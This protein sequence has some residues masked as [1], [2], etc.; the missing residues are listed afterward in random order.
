M[1]VFSS[2]IALEDK[3]SPVAAKAEHEL[4]ILNKTLVQTQNALIKAQATGDIKSFK[5]LTQKSA[6]LEAA[7]SI[8]PKPLEQVAKGTEDVASGSMAAEGEMAAMTGGLSVAIGVIIAVGAALGACVL[9]LAEFT[10][11]CVESKNAA[12]STWNA[13]GQGEIAGEDV[14]NMLDDLKLKLGVTKDQ[15]GQFA[16]GFL[17][18]GITG[19]EALES[20]TTAAASAEAI[21]KGAG[22]GFTTLFQ[23]VDAA[24]ASSTKN[25]ILPAK[26]LQKALVAA[27]LN[28]KDMAKEMGMSEEAFSSQMSKGGIDAKK[29]GDAMQ[30]AVTKKG[31][32]ALENL[33]NSSANLKAILQENIGDMFEDLGEIV[34]PFMA[35]VKSLFNIFQKDAP[36]AK[37]MTAGIK[38][39]MTQIF[40][41]ATK[42]VPI[43]KHFLLDLIIYGLKAYIGVKPLIKAIKEFAN[44][45][46]GSEKINWVLDQLATVAKVIGVALL[47]VVAVF[48]ALWAISAA[49]A[50]ALWALVGAIVGVIAEGSAA[51][52]GWVISA[53]KAAYDFVAGLVNGIANG[54]SQVVAAVTGL[55]GK[56]TGAFKSALG[57]SSPSK[58]MMGLGGFT[59]EGFAGGLESTAGAVAGA[60]EGLAATASEGLSGVSPTATAGSSGAGAGGAARGAIT[61]QAEFNF[62]GSVQGATELTEQ[63]VSVIFERI[64]LEQGL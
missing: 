37:A 60:T 2:T 48:I 8:I 4:N 57:I 47:V 7:I 39:V 44:S 40:E 45:A 14:D 59:G 58:V 27:G 64:A 17:K 38:A 34:K 12:I 3:V 16:T 36:S 42:V 31:A 43:V 51:L 63:A 62:N 54:A 32:G 41:V 20:L 61:V 11:A 15:L 56:A 24:A 35:E 33:A 29:F 22:E 25:I 5:S 50:I 55:A 18:M 28:V 26:G 52:T 19:K 1:T 9:K 46:E 53:G 30:S 10:I 13:L 21:T 6:N 23:K 49:V